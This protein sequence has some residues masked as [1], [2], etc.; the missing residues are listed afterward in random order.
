MR[1]E[2][3]QS[4]QVAR[5][6]S[7]PNVE[8]LTVAEES[9]IRK[10]HER[11]ILRLACCETHWEKVG[12]TAVTFFKRFFIERSVTEFN[13]SVIAVSALYAAFK[14]EEVHMPVDELVGAIDNI[15]N[16]EDGPNSHDSSLS[17]DGTAMRITVGALLRTEIDFL[18]RLRFHLVCYH[19]FR[20]AGLLREL[21]CQR[22]K[23][24]CSPGKESGKLI[25]VSATAHKVIMTKA[26]TTDLALTHSPA[27]IALACWATAA[28]DE[29]VE[30]DDVSAT[31]VMLE[32]ADADGKTALTNQVM[33]AVTAC[34][35]A[36]KATK[37]EMDELRV[38]EERRQALQI[39]END[40][41]SKEFRDDSD[42]SDA[43][44]GKR[45]RPREDDGSPASKRRKED[46]T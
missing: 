24:D 21:V 4:M 34:R 14:V 39:P 35:G 18:D 31:L 11:R 8:A 41:M 26:L 5:L 42:V 28:V 22:E 27:V 15:L 30:A 17:D 6:A 25:R 3:V 38:L 40:P 43:E 32:V 12:A 9:A 13:P 16:D 7:L 10:H 23:W 1:R 44:L 36:K 29:K 33:Q 20:S 19:P 37:E 45:E 2:Q 46:T